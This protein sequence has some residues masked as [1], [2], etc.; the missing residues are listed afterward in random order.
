MSVSKYKL[1]V[2]TTDKQI[3][4]PIEIKWDF[5]ERDQAIDVYQE[6]IVGDLI[7]EPTDF[8]LSRFSHQ[9]YLPLSGGTNLQT[10][11]N[12]EFNFFDSGQTI[13]NRSSS[14]SPASSWAA[15]RSVSG[16]GGC[17]SCCRARSWPCRYGYACGCTKARCSNA[18]SRKARPPR[19]R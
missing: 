9:S 13:N 19:S 11:V 7:G 2:P 5:T 12:Y 15:K 1:L 10:S 14:C 18:S 3:N 17:P 6:Q 16:A 4:I 8:E